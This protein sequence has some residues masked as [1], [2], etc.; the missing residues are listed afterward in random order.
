MKEEFVTE[1]EEI[2]KQFGKMF[3]ELLNP[4]THQVNKQN[5]YYTAKPE[6]IESTDDEIKITINALKNNKSP[7]EDGLAAELLRSTVVKNE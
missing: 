3:K 7:G 6:D 5:E 1:G 2:V 4:Q